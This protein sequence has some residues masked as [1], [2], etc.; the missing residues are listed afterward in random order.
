MQQCQGTARDQQCD[1]EDDVALGLMAPASVGST[2]AEGEPAIDGC[3]GVSRNQQRGDVGDLGRK[4]ESE[5]PEQQTEQHGAAH[6]DNREPDDVAEQTLIGARQRCARV[7]MGDGQ[8][9]GG[10]SA[11]QPGDSPQI[12]ASG[13]HDVDAGV[14]VVDPVDRNLM[15]PHPGAFGQREQFG[16]EEPGVVLHQ[17]QQNVGAIGSNGLEPALSVAE[18]D[19][20]RRAQ[21]QVVGPRDELPLGPAHDP[22]PAPQASADRDVGVAAEQGGDQRQQGVQISRQVDVHVRQYGGI[23]FQ[24][25]GAERPAPALLAQVQC[26]DLGE[27]LRQ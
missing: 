17:R 2:D 18:S 11:S 14:G 27:S 5:Y 3:V 8:A 6:A 15:D 10:E 24:P 25:G 23:G 13:R 22:R 20:Q 12:L 16:V 9:P 26:A 21:Q 1:G 4:C 7:Q 19:P